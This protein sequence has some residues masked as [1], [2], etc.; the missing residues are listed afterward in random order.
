M[1]CAP[2]EARKYHV[3]LTCLTCSKTTVY[4]YSKKKTLEEAMIIRPIYCTRCGNNN[5]DYENIIS[6]D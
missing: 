2:C 3:T 1:G 5:W 6:N 4:S